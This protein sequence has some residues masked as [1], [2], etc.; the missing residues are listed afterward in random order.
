MSTH[1]ICFYGEIWKIIP[2]SSQN[3]HLVCSTVT[4][5]RGFF[6]DPSNEMGHVKSSPCVYVLI[7]I[8]NLGKFY[9]RFRVQFWCETAL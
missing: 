1:N 7:L 4:N 8:Q 6:A 5:N 2:K 3:T 9:T